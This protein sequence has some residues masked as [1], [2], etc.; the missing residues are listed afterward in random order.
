[1]ALT[2]PQKLKIKE[3]FSIL[4]LNAPPGYKKTLGQLPP[5]VKI[6]DGL[7]TFDQVHWFVKNKS[8][9]NKDLRKVMSLI[10]DQV[11]CW[12]FFPK[13]SSGIQ[14]D[15]NRDTG[16]NE[17]MK[18]NKQW[19]NLISFDETW[20]AFGLREKT[21][22]D[23]VKASKPAERAIFQYADSKTKTIKLPGDLAEA[24]KKNAK[25]EQYFNSLA[26]SHK[27]EYLEWIITAKREETREKRVKQTI[28]MLLKDFRNP[29]EWTM[30]KA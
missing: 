19:I 24:F 2:V 23:R 11:T 10:K 22:A 6:S 15:L 8:E 3:G 26:F 16:W 4:T 12:I 13:G 20:S 28:E 30:S 7:K 29:R 18:Q 1:M 14:T 5:G 17:I 9:M 27:R 21:I 25:A